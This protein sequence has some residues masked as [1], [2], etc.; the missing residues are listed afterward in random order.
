MIK[1]SKIFICLFFLSFIGC[2][3]YTFAPNGFIVNGDTNYYNDSLKLAVGLYGDY[4]NYIPKK[5]LG[6]RVNKLYKTDNKLLKNAKIDPSETLVLF[7]GIPEFDPFYNLIAFVTKKGQDIDI[8]RGFRKKYDKDTLSY[9]YK[10][11]LI[12]KSRI[13]HTVIPSEKGQLNF[14]YYQDRTDSCAYC[15]IEQLSMSNAQRIRQNEPYK[16][17]GADCNCESEKAQQ[18]IVT[19]TIPKDSLIKQQSLIK[20]YDVNTTQL[21]CFKLLSGNDRPANINICQGRYIMIYSDLTNKVKWKK[22]IVIE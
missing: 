1:I 19:I 9:Y 16:L 8:S 11:S 3:R 10:T 5:N 18:K 6:F 14:L 21:K 7:S 12:G 20:F 13:Y 17:I 15:D 22:E 4:V 2:S